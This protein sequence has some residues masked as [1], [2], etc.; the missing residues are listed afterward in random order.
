[1]KALF[2]H[3]REEWRVPIAVA[4][5]LATGDH[6]SWHEFFSLEQAPL[7]L[8]VP[9][10]VDI[11]SNEIL[12]IFL[13]H[14]QDE[15]LPL[16]LS[17]FGSMPLEKANLVPNTVGPVTLDNFFLHTGSSVSNNAMVCLEN[18]LVRYGSPP[19]LT[20]HTLF[21]E[22]DLLID[23]L[24]DNHREIFT[25]KLGQYAINTQYSIA[26]ILNDTALMELTRLKM[27]VTENSTLDWFDVGSLQDLDK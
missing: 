6:A 19:Q 5:L 24:T 18:E 9:V 27:L 16:L 11:R 25:R 4:N 2:K 10:D 15:D 12:Q 17:T 22:C 7:Q 21:V 26:H 8:A 14:A 20:Q 3:V 23:Q 1:V 13:Y